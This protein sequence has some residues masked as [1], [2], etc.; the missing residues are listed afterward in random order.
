MV[1]G[2]QKGLGDS[3]WKGETG[4]EGLELVVDRRVWPMKK[5]EPRTNASIQLEETPEISVRGL[6]LYQI[7]QQEQK[8]GL[9]DEA[10]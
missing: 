5:E 4:K 2:G 8:A 9:Q 7:I 1:I 6:K 10:I 3:D